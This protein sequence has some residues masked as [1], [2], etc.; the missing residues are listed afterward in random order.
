MSKI[1]MFHRSKFYRH[2]PHLIQGNKLII[3]K[4]LTSD[5]N[6][7]SFFLKRIFIIDSNT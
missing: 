4:W 6:D 3:T 7:I 1:A 5:L 2:S